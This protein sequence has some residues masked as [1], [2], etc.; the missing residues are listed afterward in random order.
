MPTPSSRQAFA[1]NGDTSIRAPHDLVHRPPAIVGRTLSGQPVRQ[2]FASQTWVWHVLTMDETARLLAHYDPAAPLVQITY[3]DSTGR[4]VDAYARMQEP[5]I[6][7][8]QGPI[9]YN[10]QVVF[11]RLADQQDA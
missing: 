5:T 3:I 7:Q 4:W 10:V 6:A 1:I 2:G 9:N 11:E 8:R